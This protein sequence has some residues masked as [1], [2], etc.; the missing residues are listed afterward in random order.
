MGILTIPNA[1]MIPVAKQT[2]SGIT[3][4]AVLDMSTAFTSAY[5]IYKIFINIDN[6][7]A[8]N[9]LQMRYYDGSGTL[10]TASSY[11]SYS[12]VFNGS[13]SYSG[14]NFGTSTAFQLLNTE[15]YTSNQS[16]ATAEL[17]VWNPMKTA[18]ITQASAIIATLNTAG[19][20]LTGHATHAWTSTGLVRGFQLYP[21]SGTVNGT[22][23]VY[24][25][26]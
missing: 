8:D 16:Y 12:K 14:E 24:G 6:S 13:V 9:T 21:N 10:L 18:A 23:S 3:S 11:L 17:T 7:T 5:D 20:W 22:V 1:G 26:V 19:A 25:V 2:F 15:T 4:A